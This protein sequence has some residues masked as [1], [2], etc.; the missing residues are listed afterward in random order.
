MPL[1]N[2]DDEALEATQSDRERRQGWMIAL[3]VKDDYEASE[4]PLP[5]WVVHALGQ[6]E[7]RTHS[8]SPCGKRR[9]I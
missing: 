4:S 2:F 8:E 7:W 9:R 3:D 6:N 5:A 1:E